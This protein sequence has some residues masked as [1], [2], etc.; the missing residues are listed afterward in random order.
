MSLD[1]AWVTL[2][3]WSVCH[4]AVLCGVVDWTQ[5]FMHSKQSL[6]PLNYIHSS[7]IFVN[8]KEF[9]TFRQMLDCL[10]SK[11]AHT[12]P[13]TPAHLS[14]HTW[15]F[16]LSVPSLFPSWSFCYSL[17]TVYKW[18]VP[19]LR[20]T[21]KRKQKETKRGQNSR[22]SIESFPVMS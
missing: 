17:F 1:S 20:W 21:G 10:G 2:N 14:R 9:I 15:I 4:Q 19:W 16:L 8:S 5:S 3:S 7:K 6:Y 13:D 11:P 18:W 22:R 12:T